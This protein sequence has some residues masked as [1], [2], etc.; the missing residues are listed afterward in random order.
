[1]KNSKKMTV[2]LLAL[3]LAGSFSLNAQRGGRGMRADSAEMNRMRMEQRQIPMMMQ[4]PDSM[5]MGDMRHCMASVQMDQ[6]GRFMC[7]CMM[8]RPGMGMMCHGMQRPGM[9]MN[10]APAMRIIDNIPNL[11][12]KQKKDIADL[13][14]KQLDEMQKFRNEMQVK[15]KEMRESQRSKVMSL[16]TDEQKKWFEA[17][18][19]VPAPMNK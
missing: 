8:R 17:N 4:H 14:Q 18:A 6:M 1:M 2:I 16:L 5:K 13:K 15:I 3:L 19:P 12:E 11:T 7:P 9:E 10:G